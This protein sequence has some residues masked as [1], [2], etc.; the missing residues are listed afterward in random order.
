MKD[1]ERYRHVFSCSLGAKT[2]HPQASSCS[3]RDNAMGLRWFTDFSRCTRFC[4][5]LMFRAPLLQKS[6]GLKM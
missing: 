1:Q 5:P 2:A 3:H 6:D 4:E